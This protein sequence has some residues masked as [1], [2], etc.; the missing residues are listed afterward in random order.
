[1]QGLNLRKSIQG[2]RCSNDR[3]KE[4][5]YKCKSLVPS[6][7]PDPVG[8]VPEWWKVQGQIPVIAGETWYRVPT[9]NINSFVQRK[10]NMQR[11]FLFVQPR[12]KYRR[13][14]VLL[15]RS[16][17]QSFRI[18]QECLDGSESG[19]VRSAP[20]AISELYLWWV[21]WT[22][23]CWPGH[24]V[25]GGWSSPWRCSAD[26]EQSLGDKSTKHLK[27]HTPIS[28]DAGMKGFLGKPFSWASRGSAAGNKTWLLGGLPSVSL[29]GQRSYRS[30]T[31]RFNHWRPSGSWPD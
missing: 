2:E 27:S 26:W 18:F 13:G 16:R 24:L 6:K 14:Y 20:W 11:S 28:L 23:L 8:Q 19:E 21:T 22:H 9:L 7:A 5:H 3:L 12:R 25:W 10:T 4:N 31:K 17:A 15:T 30:R 29:S 1:M